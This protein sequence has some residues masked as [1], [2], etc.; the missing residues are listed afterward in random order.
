GSL[1]FKRMNLN[2]AK[3]FFLETGN[4]AIISNSKQI[5]LNAGNQE[6]LLRSTS[7]NKALEASDKNKTSIF[8]NH[9]LISAE[10]STIFQNMKFP[11]IQNFAAWSV[12]DI[13]I[14]DAN[15]KLNG[16]SLNGNK[17]NILNRFRNINPQQ[18]EI[19][20]ICPDDFISFYSVGF[21]NF[22]KLYKNKLNSGKD[23]IRS[24]YP[25]ILK[26]ARES[27]S[28]VLTNGNVL[29]LNINEIESAKETLAGLGN[30]AETFR[31]T[32]II[33]LNEGINFQEFFPDLMILETAEFY[34]IQDHFV[35]FSAN[36]D[37]L[38]SMI[39]AVQ[40]SDTLNDTQY[41]NDLMTSL[42]SETSILFVVNSAN[43]VKKWRKEDSGQQFSFNKNSLAAFQ[44]INEGDYSHLHG[45]L[46]N[47]EK[48]A[49]SN[50]AE[51][52]SSINI[53]SPISM[54]PV[55]FK[56]HRTD[57]MDIAVQD[58]NNELYLISN[59]GNIF[60]KKTMDS[61][62]TSPIYQVDL[63]KNGNKQMAFSTGYQMEVL[64]RTGKKVKG[65]PIKFNQPLTQPLSV[66]DYDN[67]RTYRFVLTQNKKIYMVG[68]KGK[69][70]KGFSFE[71]A[72]S[73]VIKAPKHIRLGTK[74]YILIAEET[75][76]LNILSRQGKIRV[77]VSEKMDFSENEWF[78]YQ[79]SFVS[80]NPKQSL[81]KISQNGTV[82]T[83]DLGLAE[84]NRIVADRNN[85]VY[86][87]ENELSINSKTIN[88]DFGLYTD[89][90]LFTVRNR[91]LIAI[92]D[93]QTQ[94]VYVFN[95][96]AELL[97]GFPV[98]GTS[99]VDIANAD[100]DSKLELVV[101]G[102]ENEILVYEF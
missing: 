72:D 50:G 77:P 65:Y 1:E 94:K 29:A 15:I 92:T 7:F 9:E 86:L 58:E 71:K 26:H 36:P 43:F 83:T 23:T 101:R 56:N 97:E 3:F 85:L 53:D 64:D 44:V 12:L 88:L 21:S 35:I 70:I 76:K 48:A 5:I 46:S 13:D 82:S 33:E 66:F 73:E 79:N 55:F 19:G 95:D 4:A 16:I 30:V 34:I 74:D 96:N 42:S 18:S 90:Q 69:A 45:I 68:P 11:G 25:G 17:E 28:I 84:N 41:F 47:S 2:E 93:T 81:V 54:A 99:S 10:L 61:Q 100:L 80:T 6:K 8:L 22:E 51:Q 78:G 24:E 14:S 32:E 67:N 38:K 91:T 98:Y 49:K 63:F 27:V 59:K 102:E 60:W 75:G 31:G 39:A 87:N 89:P 20:K 62:I 40:N 57:Q 52:S 37:A